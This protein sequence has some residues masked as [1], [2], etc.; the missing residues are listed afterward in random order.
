MERYSERQRERVN[1]TE[2]KK[3]IERKCGKTDV[4]RGR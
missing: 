1:D 3:K 4:R 2:R